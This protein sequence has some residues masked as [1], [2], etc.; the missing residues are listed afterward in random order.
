[1]TLGGLM[2][3][4]LPNKAILPNSKENIRVGIIG[5]D[6]SYGVSFAKML[7]SDDPLFSGLRVVAAYPKGS[8][9][10]PLSVS[11]IDGYTKEIQQYG[12]QIVKSIK[13]LLRKVDAVIIV[14]NDGTIRLSQALEVI[15]AKKPL[16][17]G[18]PAAASLK[19]VIKIY[20]EAKKH[21]VPV[22]SSS[23][24]RYFENAKH[25]STEKSGKVLGAETYSPAILEP[26]HPDFFWYGIH[27]IEML[28]TVLGTGCKSVYRTHTQDTDL[29]TGV[30]SDGRIGVFR[31]IRSG[32][33]GHGGNAFCEKDIV[34]LIS[35]KEAN[36]HLLIEITKFL[37][38]KQPP[39]SADETIEIYAFM[40]AA[41]ESKRLNGK[42]VTIEEVIIKAKIEI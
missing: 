10:I 29:V 7:N 38:T 5:L 34:S 19:D 20:K 40:Q 2:K 6:I 1:M 25:I 8:E 30:W 9:K 28:Y 23:S 39:I 37:K 27:G 26:T 13:Q 4:R 42:P 15:R 16:F 11:R 21:K 24:M 17:M 35:S 41:D 18:K 3:L 36:K 14:S 12:V 33:K 32:K 22:F 31:G